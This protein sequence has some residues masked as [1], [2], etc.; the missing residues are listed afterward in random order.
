M[1][2]WKGIVALLLAL[3]LTVPLTGCGPK[4]ASG[5]T[6]GPSPSV[7]PSESPS[8]SPSETPSEAPSATFDLAV[9]L[10]SEP[11]SIDPARNTTVDGGI[12]VQHLFEGL[13]KWV[14][15]GKAVDSHANAAQL[16][17]GMAES[18]ERVE[19]EDG[20]ATYT[21]RLRE[22]KWTD[23]KPVTAQNFVYAWQRLVTPA[24]SA[25]YSYLLSCV[26]NAREVMS[27][28]K[29]AAELGVEAVDDKTFA[30]T[31]HDVPYFL[32]LC[33]APATFPVRQDV[34]EANGD[35]WTYT[36]ETCVSNGPYKLS[37]W[38]HNAQLVM[39]PN[40]TYYDPA[41]Q[42]PDSITFR[43]TDDQEAV[44]AAYKDG[45]LDFI[46]DVPVDEVAG[47]LVSGELNL[48]D[49]I[50]TYFVCF[51]NQ[52]APFDDAR[53]RKAF[54]LAV[55]RNYLVE[56]VTQT[57][58]TEAGGFVPSG[59]YDDAG[60]TGAD[61]RKNGGDYF[62]PSREGYEA[63]CEEA[64]RLLAEAGYPNG[65]GF[66]VVEYLYN[67]GSVHQAVAEALRDMWQDVLGVKVTLTAQGWAEFLQARK[68]GNYSI[69]RN[70]WTAD[71]NDPM[72]FLDMW[73]SDSGNNDAKYAN[74]DYDK[75][76]QA[77]MDAADP[78]QRMTLMHQAEDI[79]IGEDY[80]LCPLYFYTQKYMLDPKVDGLV[81]SPLGYFFFNTCKKAE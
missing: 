54:T 61:F 22:A 33:A 17:P 80:A 65:E 9:N 21:F 15:S 32:Q 13:M 69:A 60:P 4:E 34:I 3:A 79:L 23:G 53:V 45:S 48:M 10:A 51:Q 73:R 7:S 40:E 5:E 56:R 24:T 14:D 39:V 72:S 27:G 37:A 44:L 55:D 76:I 12:M 28:E 81:Y 59:I 52:K 64:K 62:D 41:C 66:P 63:N 25:S 75:L 18:Y 1:K 46:R 58:Q 74:E 29:E 43:L 67:T 35:Q 71:Y 16:V 77:A 42:G 8:P 38:E 20:T 57:G 19:N 30:V 36:P 47:L 2:H 11:R 68:E 6:P 31:V 26:V 49:Y 78:S 70:G 50:G